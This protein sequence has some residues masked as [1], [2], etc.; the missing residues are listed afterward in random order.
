MSA[1]LALLLADEFGEDLTGVT[2]LSPTLFFDGW[3]IPWYQCFLL[4]LYM[5]PLKHFFYFKEDPP[6]GIKNKAISQLVHRYYNNASLESIDDEGVAKYGYP[7]FPVTLLYQLHLLVK[8]IKPRLSKINIPVQCIQAKDDDTTSVR[9]S[10]Y[11]YDHI[12][13]REKEIALLYDSYHVITA[14]QERD[15][16]A[17]KM[18]EFFNKVR[19]AHVR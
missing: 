10:Q 15:K 9:N 16:V 19:T 2:C 5:T 17:L 6:Y 12:S 7:Y 1:L 8:Y 14:D 18:E 11:I 3:N 4:P 13:S